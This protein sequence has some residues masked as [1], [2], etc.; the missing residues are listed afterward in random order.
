MR[1]QT[2]PASLTPDRRHRRR[3]AEGCVPDV[4]AVMAC[5]KPGHDDRKAVSASAHSRYPLATVTIRHCAGPAAA[6]HPRRS[7]K[8][9]VL[10]LTSW[11]VLILMVIGLVVFLVWPED[12]R[13][14]RVLWIVPF[15]MAYVG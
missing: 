9:L 5:D 10:F 14:M 11:P 15:L 12:D 2:M 7:M 4:G 13:W 1:A 6:G 8:R 3:L